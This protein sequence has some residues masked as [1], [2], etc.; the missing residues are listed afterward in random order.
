M[1]WQSAF[2]VYRIMPDGKLKEIYHA[3]D[4]KSAQYWLSYIAQTG[5]LCCRTP[6]SPRHS[7]KSP[8][9]EYIG[10]KESS[11]KASRIEADWKKWA[12]GRQ[13]DFCFPGEQ[14]IEHGKARAEE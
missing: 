5:D 3:Q 6:A 7:G 4:L 9:P 13:F 2:V 8:Q 10:H 11:G 14:M 1:D 12:E